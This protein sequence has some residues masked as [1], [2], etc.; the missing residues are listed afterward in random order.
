[1]L[2]HWQLT[3]FLRAAGRLTTT[4]RARLKKAIL[5]LQNLALQ[6]DASGAPAWAT[7]Q[8]RSGTTVSTAGTVRLPGPRSSGTSTT[9]LAPGAAAADLPRDAR[10]AW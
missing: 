1:M 9:S 5:H 2:N 3:L 4:V 7:V 10:G 8:E 6:E